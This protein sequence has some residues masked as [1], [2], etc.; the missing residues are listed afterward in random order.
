MKVLVPIDFSECSNYAHG[1]IS[2]IRKSLNAKIVLLNVAE[3]EQEAQEAMEV[4]DTIKD[5]KKVVRVG[6]FLNELND[7]LADYEFD[8]IVMGTNGVSGIRQQI[9]GSNTVKALRNIN[10]PILT[11]KN[12]FRKSTINNIVFISAFD[13]NE[14]NA[15]KVTTDFAAHFD[16]TVHLLSI[17]TLKY[18]DEVPFM[19]N[20]AIKEFLKEKAFL[21]TKV[22]R[23]ESFTVKGGL[24]KFIESNDVDLIALATSTTTGIRNLFL[25]SIAES[26]I[27]ATKIPTLIIKK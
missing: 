27:S 24:K 21:K 26:V 2:K 20:K 10:I 15:F 8:L 6:N 19:V 17:D 9:I 25:R 1:F 11:I 5:V 7:I 4:F 13:N 3:N 23:I 16:S 12:H 18:F 22:H 14:I